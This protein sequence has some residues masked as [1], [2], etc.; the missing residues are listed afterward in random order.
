MGAH[1]RCLASLSVEFLRWRCKDQGLFS[2]GSKSDPVSRLAWFERGNCWGVPAPSHIKLWRTLDELRECELKPICTD[3]GLASK[4]RK[5]T[6]LDR[7]RE[8]GCDESA[9]PREDEIAN[10][11]QKQTPKIMLSLHSSNRTADE[12]LLLRFSNVQRT[13]VQLV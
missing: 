3:L 9:L 10:H 12:D 5:R 2:Q 7:L 13:H 1:R 6:L 11:E 8:A 4:G